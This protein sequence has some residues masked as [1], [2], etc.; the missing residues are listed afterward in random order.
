VLTHLV[1]WLSAVKSVLKIGVI[2]V[3]VG[4]SNG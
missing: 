3:R 4:R 1:L 2:R